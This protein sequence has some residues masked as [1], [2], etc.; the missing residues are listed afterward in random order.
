M[1]A[2]VDHVSLNVSDLAKSKSFYDSL[3]IFL[4]FKAHTGDGWTNDRNGIWINQ[5]DEEH[6]VTAHDR[7]NIGITHLA[8][9]LETKAEVDRFHEQFL[10]PNKVFVLYGGPKEYPQYT[11]GYYA[12][13]F[14]DPDGF[15][16]E[17]VYLP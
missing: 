9:R 16:L 17:A 2:Y 8:F 7:K 1:K 4:G 15:K 10:L 11:E 5:A 13:F 3:L 12:V 6:R 14:E